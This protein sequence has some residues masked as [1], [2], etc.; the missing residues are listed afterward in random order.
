[1]ALRATEKEITVFIA[2]L[3]NGKSQREA[4]RIA[5][6]ISKR[7]KDESVDAKASELFAVDKVRERYNKLLQKAKEQI[8]N[9]CFLTYAEKRRILQEFANDTEARKDERMKAIDLDNKMEG[10]YIN[11]TELTGNNGGPLEFVWAG[12]SE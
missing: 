6:P 11:R 5:K 4:Y 7:W 2:E 1:M 10:V 12:D 8:E 9:E 3:I